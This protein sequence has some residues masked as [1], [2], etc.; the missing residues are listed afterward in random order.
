[1][2]LNLPPKMDVNPCLNHTMENH[3][4]ACAFSTVAHSLFI[5]YNIF[6]ALTLLA[7][8]TKSLYLLLL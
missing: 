8:M 1:M 4:D 5:I 7:A 6:S 3:H 2:L